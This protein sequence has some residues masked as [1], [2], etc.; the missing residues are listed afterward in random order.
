VRNAAVL[1]TSK[2]HVFIRTDEP[3]HDPHRERKSPTRRV[4]HDLRRGKLIVR[5]ASFG[6]A[7]T[8]RQ[9]VLYALAS[10]AVGEATMKPPGAR[11][12]FTGVG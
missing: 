1:V 11:K 9:H 12:T 6:V 3:H 5:P 2:L 4:T 8:C 7:P 10:A